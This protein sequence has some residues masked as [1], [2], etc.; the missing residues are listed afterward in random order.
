MKAGPFAEIRRVAA[1]ING[2]VPNVTGE[3]SNEFALRPFE[4]VMQAA[5]HTFG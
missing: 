5:K 4:L 1:E 3:Y 2:H